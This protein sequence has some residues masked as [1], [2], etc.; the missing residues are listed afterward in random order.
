[1]R[2]SSPTLDF[3]LQPPHAQLP[4]APNAL[5]PPSSHSWPYLGHISTALLVL[6]WSREQPLPGVAAKYDPNAV[7]FNTLVI[8][9][10]GFVYHKVV[11]SVCES[12]VSTS[13]TE[14]CQ[15]A[16]T[17]VPLRADGHLFR[18]ALMATTHGLMKQTD[19]E[20]DTFLLV[21][22][23]GPVAWH[24]SFIVMWVADTVRANYVCCAPGATTTPN[25]CSQCPLTWPLPVIFTVD[26]GF[27][28]LTRV[29]RIATVKQS[30][31]GPG[32]APDAYTHVVRRPLACTSNK[33]EENRGMVVDVEEQQCEATQAQ[34]KATRE[35]PST[36]NKLLR[37]GDKFVNTEIKDPERR[38]CTREIRTWLRQYTKK[39][40]MTEFI[41]GS[42][43]LAQELTTMITMLRDDLARREVIVK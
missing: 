5:R 18:S 43:G 36:H 40:F 9:P 31:P 14:D 6:G 4:P 20:A 41:H 35:P 39:T 29:I 27:Y 22:S 30:V 26:A 19:T 24:P 16:T 21:Y 25:M 10:V 28:V 15:V 7:I 23:S 8:S 38:L 1:M 37:R 2:V 12:N 17:G 13:L 3:S 32:R 11:F 42:R 34:V 33:N